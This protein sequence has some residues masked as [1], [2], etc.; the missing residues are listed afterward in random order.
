MYLQRYLNLNTLLEQKSFFLLGPRTTGKTSLINHQLLQDASLS[1]NLLK[2]NVFLKLNSKP[3]EL[4]EMIDASLHNASIKFIVIDEIQKIPILLNEVHR[5]IE[6]KKIKFLLTG[7]SARKLKKDNIN[8][9]AGRAWEAQL[10]PLIMNEIPNFSLNRY[11]KFGGLPSVYLSQNPT[12]ELISYVDTYLKEEIQA[13]ALVRKIQSFSKFLQISAL[14]SGTMLNFNSLSNDVGIPASTVREYYQI[15]QDTLVGFLLP[16]WTK[17]KKRKAISTAKFYFF[18][19]GVAHQLA[20]IQS[21]DPQSDLYGRA[22]EHFIAMELR[23]YLSYTR[24]HLSLNYWCSVHGQE[25]DFIIADEIAIEV[26]TTKS[27]NNKHLKGLKILQ[28]EN[29]CKKYFLISLDP[30]HR[31]SEGIEIIYWE[32]FL[33]NLWQNNYI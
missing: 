2:S 4:E 22:F 24:K 6:E 1:I 33:Q 13:E 14:T 17:T 10:F 27:I 5:L 3:W 21:I 31:I 19:I 7:S 18:D 8:L 9:L 11:L 16:A 12:E 26:K 29:L 25:V 20:E 23:A 15:L 32:N 28:E 30:I